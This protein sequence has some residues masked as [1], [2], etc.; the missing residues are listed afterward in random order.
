MAYFIL[1][2]S[3]LISLLCFY[4]GIRLLRLYFKV[5][6]WPKAKAIISHKAI[7]LKKSANASRAGY[8]LDIQYT[9]TTPLQQKQAG[10]RVFL[11]EFL[12]GQK[13]FLKNAAQKHID[14]LPDEVEIFYNPEDLLES[15]M[16]C[17]GLGLYLIVILMGFVSPLIGLAQFL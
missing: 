14:Q 4:Y 5:K 15:V 11:V 8:V 16:Y 1:I 10:H 9:F 3:L 13:A 6:R 7:A 12:K 2:F 17:D